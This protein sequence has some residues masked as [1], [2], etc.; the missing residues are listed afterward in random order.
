MDPAA[1]QGRQSLRWSAI[2]PA[3]GART[4]VQS[5][6]KVEGKEEEERTHDGSTAVDDI[7]K[8]ADADATRYPAHRDDHAYHRGERR[9]FIASPPGP[10]PLPHP[11]ATVR[12]MQPTALSESG[13]NDDVSYVCV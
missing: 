3:S 10:P 8:P 7:S 12:L 5:E 9:S 6:P 1:H 4:A 2:D 11:T 13:G